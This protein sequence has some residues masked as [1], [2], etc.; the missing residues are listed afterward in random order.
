M[1]NRQFAE[2]ENGKFADME[3][4]YFGLTTST[5]NRMLAVIV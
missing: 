1:E 2:F 4:K 3:L 5:S